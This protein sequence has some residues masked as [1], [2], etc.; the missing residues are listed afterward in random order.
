MRS[1]A[2]V[3]LLSSHV[4]LACLCGDRDFNRSV[5]RGDSVFVGTVV[6]KVDVAAGPTLFFSQQTLVDV[7][8]V[9]NGA[10]PGYVVL[11]SHR[12]CWPTFE[13]GDQMLFYVGKDLVVTR[14]DLLS[15]WS[16]LPAERGHS[17]LSVVTVV[18]FF[19]D[20]FLLMV[21][22]L[23]RSARLEKARQDALS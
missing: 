3:V 6:K 16:D 19:A 23:R 12:G 5:R 15:D 14:C 13:E 21:L 1:L 11:E 18:A 9:W 8:R 20:A 7:Q 10:V 2:A 22:L 4:A 17:P